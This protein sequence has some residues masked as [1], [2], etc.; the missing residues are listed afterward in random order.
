MGHTG[1]QTFRGRPRFTNLTAGSALDQAARAC[2][3][4]RGDDA[5]SLCEQALEKI[6]EAKKFILKCVGADSKKVKITEEW[7]DAAESM[8]RVTYNLN[9]NQQNLLNSH[10]QA[11]R[12][13][14]TDTVRKLEAERTDLCRRLPHLEKALKRMTKED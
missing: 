13:Y 6:A 1:P 4:T 5:G 14:F 7:A 12:K 3:Q 11:G 8:A 10:T 9:I 2:T